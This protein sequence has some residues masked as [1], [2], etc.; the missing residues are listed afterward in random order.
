MKRRLLNLLTALSLVLC[1]LAAA[2]GVRSRWVTEAWAL[3][4][5]P[6]A[7]APSNNRWGIESWSLCRWVRSSEGRLMLLAREL[8]DNPSGYNPNWDRPGYHRYGS[9]WGYSRPLDAGAP[10][11]RRWVAPGIEFYAS[12]T[13]FIANPPPMLVG[14]RMDGPVLL[15]G[16][17][18][19]SVSWWIP[20]FAASVLPGYRAWRWLARWRGA[21]RFRHAGLCPRCG[22]DLRATPGRC[23]ECG[24]VAA[25][26]P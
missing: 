13:Q 24:T 25:S 12:D 6:A 3:E 17:R 16:Q 10:G 19:V 21:R 15:Q 11:E 26:S 14:L 1:L 2:M 7:V 18:F 23:P 5:R 4:P 22:Y 9:P 20:A 8:P